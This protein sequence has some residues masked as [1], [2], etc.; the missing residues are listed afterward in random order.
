VLTRNFQGKTLTVHVLEAGFRYEDRVYRSLS[1]VA[2]R[3]SGTQWN[4]FLF[5]GRAL[6]ESAG[7]AQMSGFDR[8][9]GR[10]RYL[11]G[12]HGNVNVDEATNPR[13]GTD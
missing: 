1:A 4:G 2:R 11:V 9:S 5:F 10:G 3:I 8:K 6:R 12:A 13:G 7:S